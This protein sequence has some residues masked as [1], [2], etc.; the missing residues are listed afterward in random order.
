MPIAVGA[1]VGYPVAFATRHAARPRMLA[2]QVLALSRAVVYGFLTLPVAHGGYEALLMR[3]RR[4]DCAS[5]SGMRPTPGSSRTTAPTRP[6]AVWR[7][8]TR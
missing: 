8:T 5:C 7:A 6:T 3:R 4:S 2:D 1:A